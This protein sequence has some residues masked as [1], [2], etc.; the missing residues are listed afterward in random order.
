MQEMTQPSRIGSSIVA[1]RCVTIRPTMDIIWRE[2]Y[3]GLNAKEIDKKTRTLPV[4]PRQSHA[5]VEATIQIT[6]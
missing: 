3:S 1:V 6:W 4:E 5:Q 2:I